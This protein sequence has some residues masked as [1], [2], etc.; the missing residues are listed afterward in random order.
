MA[1]DPGP[2][3]AGGGEGGPA[4]AASEVREGIPEDVV[5]QARE[6]LGEDVPYFVEVWNDYDPSMR[7][8]SLF[9]VGEE[10]GATLSSVAYYIIEPG[11][12]SGVHSDN[13]EEVVFVAEGAGEVFTMGRT[14]KLEAGK[15]VVLPAGMGHDIYA[16]GAVALRLLS[17]FPTPEILSTFQQVIFPIGGNVLSSKPPG[18]VVTELDPNNLPE[19]F[20]FDLAELGLAPVSEPREPTMTERL[21]GLVGE[22]AATPPA[23]EEPAGVPETGESAADPP[24]EG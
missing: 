17:F 14:E 20:P 18:P 4:E 21:L 13:A 22:P 15:F 16:Y 23:P 19:D 6:E 10:Q 8:V 2:G 11:K 1:E 3:P 7:F 12:H 5:A 9:P 24:G